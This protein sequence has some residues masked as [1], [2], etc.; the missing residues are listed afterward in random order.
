MV[1]MVYTTVI[2]YDEGYNKYCKCF[3]YFIQSLGTIIV[4]HR[5][6]L[7]LGDWEW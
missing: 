4:Y 3:R 6:N 5:R 7:E 1:I 2:H